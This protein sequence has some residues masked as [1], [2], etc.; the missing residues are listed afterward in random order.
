MHPRLN[1][2]TI[3]IAQTTHCHI[4]MM[5]DCRWPWVIVIPVDDKITE[6]HQ[7]QTPLQHAFMDQVNQVATHLQEL[8]ACR[9]INV[10]ML[11]NVVSQLH[12]HVIARHSED[13]NWPEPV[14]GFGEGVP[15]SSDPDWH[16]SLKSMLS[17][18]LNA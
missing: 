15:Y 3:N 16:G 17:K 9:S 14:W 13:P 12:C 18:D 2:D 1:A 4:R 5:N 7:M 11:G 6:L 10:A 8:T